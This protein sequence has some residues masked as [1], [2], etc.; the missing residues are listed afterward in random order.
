MKTRS[1]QMGIDSESQDEFIRKNDDHAK[2]QMEYYAEQKFNAKPS[3]L[4]G[5]DTVVLKN[6]YKSKRLQTYDPRPYKG[7]DK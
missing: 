6:D 2:L 5:S 3:R 1:P 4:E 7:V